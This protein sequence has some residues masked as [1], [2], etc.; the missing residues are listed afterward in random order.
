M[1]DPSGRHAPI[2]TWDARGY[3][4]ATSVTEVRMRSVPRPS[5]ELT[6]NT[7][8][9]KA[10]GLQ[11]Q[12]KMFPAPQNHSE[13]HGELERHPRQLVLK[14]T[15]IKQS[16]DPFITRFVTVRNCSYQLPTSMISRQDPSKVVACIYG[17]K[18]C[19]RTAKRSQGPLPCRS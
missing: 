9:T 8:Y 10:L 4:P 1:V 17:S 5:P 11:C 2:I 16:L 18:R 12:C 3:V 19:L 6:V 14:R 13:A 15:R 7:K